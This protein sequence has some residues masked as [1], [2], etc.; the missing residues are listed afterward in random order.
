MDSENLNGQMGDG[1][2]VNGKM[3]NSM[4]MEFIFLKVYILFLVMKIT[5]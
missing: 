2:K 3:E 4:D 5:L 1:I